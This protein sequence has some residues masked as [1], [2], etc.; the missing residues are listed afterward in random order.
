MSKIK[1]IYKFITYIQF[2]GNRFSTF[3][4]CERDKKLDTSSG[5]AVFPL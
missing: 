2:Y 4:F 1:I 3:K 5:A